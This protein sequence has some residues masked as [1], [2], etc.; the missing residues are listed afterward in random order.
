[1]RR[2]GSNN[3]VIACYWTDLGSTTRRTNL[4]EEVDV[5]LVVVAPLPWKVILVVDGF[6][7]TDWLASTAIHTLVR[8]NVE[9]TVALIDAVNWTFVDAS[10]VLDVNARKG[11]YVSQ[12]KLLRKNFK[13]SDAKPALIETKKEG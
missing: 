2:Q 6:D 9:H 13:F 8:V 10:F 12:S 3:W 1:M 11:N 4:I 5:D 7:W